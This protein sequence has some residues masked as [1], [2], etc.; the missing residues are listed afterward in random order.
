MST[1][2]TIVK[3]PSGHNL[4]VTVQNPGA[5]AP[6]TQVLGDNQATEVMVYGG[7]PEQGGGILTLHEVD[8]PKETK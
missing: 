7:S 5:G 8:K 4:Q 1:H 2:V 6:V 3:K